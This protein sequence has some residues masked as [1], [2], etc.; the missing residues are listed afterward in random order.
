MGDASHSL[1]RNFI[2]SPEEGQNKKRSVWPYKSIDNKQA[3]FGL[4]PPTDYLSQ[5]C[6]IIAKLDR[7]RWNGVMTC[8]KP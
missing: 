8:G 7:E 3:Y 1:E 2:V 4:D 6:Q 5:R